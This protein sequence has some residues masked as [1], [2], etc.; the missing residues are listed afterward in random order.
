MT[1]QVGKLDTK[2]RLMIPGGF[3]GYL[4]LKPGS[5]VLVNLDPEKAR[6]VITPTSEKQ[7]TL[8]K[9]GLS[10]KPGSLAKIAKAL[11]DAGIDLVSTES[12]STSRGQSAE[13]LVTCSSSSIRD[14]NAIKKAALR[15]GAT[16]FAAKRP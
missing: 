11:A 12:R 9:I 3:R 2:G 10:D 6:I 15:A 4:R 5:E 8:I 16:N 13:W 1:S 14:L 7:L